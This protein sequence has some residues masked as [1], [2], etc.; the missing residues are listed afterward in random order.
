MATPRQIEHCRK[1]ARAGGLARAKAFTSEYQKAARAKRK[2]ETLVA[3]GL[4]SYVR[5]SYNQGF[6]DTTFMNHIK[7]TQPELIADLLDDNPP[8]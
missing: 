3:A 1:I 5:N 7:S 6:T 4:K 8:F 2:R